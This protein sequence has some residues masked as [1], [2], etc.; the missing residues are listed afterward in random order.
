MQLRFNKSAVILAVSAVF[1]TAQAQV[2]VHLDPYGGTFAP[3]GIDSDKPYNR[4]DAAIDR[5][6]SSGLDVQIAGGKTIYGPKTIDRAVTLTSVGGPTTIGT[7]VISETSLRCVTYNVRLNGSGIGPSGWA[8]AQRATAIRNYNW[9][10]A[11]YI[12]MCEI[13]NDF[14][15]F[16]DSF[17]GLPHQQTGFNT[18]SGFA[19]HSGLASVCAHPIGQVA[20]GTFSTW[21]FTDGFAA[22][23]WIRSRIEKNGIGIWFFMTHLNADDSAEPSWS[24]NYA[25][26]QAQM[27]Q[28]AQDIANIR[29]DPSFHDE[30]FVIMGDFNVYGEDREPSGS[31]DQNEHSQTMGPL[32]GTAIG[33]G[34]D[35]ARHFT[36]AEAP[37]KVA[38]TFSGANTLARYF[39]DPPATPSDPDCCSPTAD[40]S[41]ARLDYIIALSSVDGKV[42][43]EPTNYEVIRG[44]S[45][46]NI[47]EGETIWLYDHVDRNL[48]DH[49]GIAADFRIMR[50]AN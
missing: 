26:R 24:F 20:R 30:V 2:V 39:Y 32:L 35:V 47:T 49:Y 15:N 50:V 34:M 27:A 45:P 6:N 33:G 11:D 8:N 28:L 19:T 42:L 16:L 18:P 12:G 5:G 3:T 36:L 40:S 22:K 29:S 4:L 7:P 44:M 25:V 48:S 37:D 17:P 41:Q 23:G 14:T 1:A 46:T 9:G 21:T 10:G 43:I 38:Y 31:P 13:W